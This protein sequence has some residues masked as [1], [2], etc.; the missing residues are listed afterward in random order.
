M[1]SKIRRSVFSE[2]LLFPNEASLMGH[3]QNCTVFPRWVVGTAAVE[4]GLAGYGM[5]LSVCHSYQHFL[6]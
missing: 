1:N 5:T 2:V 4:A 6:R 3:L